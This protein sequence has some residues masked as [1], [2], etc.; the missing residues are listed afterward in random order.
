MSLQP[1]VS[2]KIPQEIFDL[3]VY[4]SRYDHNALYD[5]CL[6]S[7]YFKHEA[8]RLLY[9]ELRIS[10]DGRPTMGSR[11][12]TVDVP[13]AT[14]LF[15]T[16]TQYNPTLS[17]HTRILYHCI[18]GHENDPEYWRLLNQSLISMINLQKI[19]LYR[20]VPSSIFQDCKTF[21]LQNLECSHSCSMPSFRSSILDFLDVQPKLESLFIVWDRDTSFP[22]TLCR[23]LKLLAGDRY[24][25]ERIL[26][27][28]EDS[29]TKLT[30]V[31]ARDE[32][33]H[34]SNLD[35]VTSGLSNIQVLSLGGYHPRP[36]LGILVPY[37]PS[38]RILRL[39]GFANVRQ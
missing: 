32:Y 16:L 33:W 3:I 26:P 35:I 7:S 19:T 6:V 2:Q 37:L 4:H 23:N 36:H 30:W 5:L 1:D 29:I 14:K 27:G 10:N 38:L 11:A 22:S 12:I 13:S 24:T 8:Q 9:Y 20:Y 21:R 39:I 17:T 25:I 15:L 18:I 28:R 31:P 34:N